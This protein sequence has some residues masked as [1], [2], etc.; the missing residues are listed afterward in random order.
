M[1]VGWVR[2]GGQTWPDRVDVT[3]SDLPGFPARI[4]ILSEDVR[5]SAPFTVLFVC[6][7]NLCRSPLAERLLRARLQERLGD[8][9]AAV[10]VES[11]GTRA[12]VR[13]PMDDMAAQ[14]LARL[15][16]SNDHFRAHRLSAQMLTE[17]DLVLTATKE[18][19]SRVLEDVPA[20]LR[21][22]FTIREFAALVDGVQVD[23]PKSLVAD[24]AQRRSS[25]QLQEYDVP[26]PIGLGAAA[27]RVSADL[28][29]AS[30]TPVA[31]AIAAAVRHA[32][33]VVSTR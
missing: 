21:R 4:G 8:L 7:G 20:A 30:L 33:S 16:F 22:T 29:D 2:D 25:A 28:I 26:D 10:I 19:R 32:E 24:A 9:S 3:G 12:V 17:A 6:V 18:L 5:V 27:H 15:G 23:S 13:E 31:E 1:R 14:E 11:A